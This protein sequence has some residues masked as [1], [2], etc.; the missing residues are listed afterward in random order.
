MLLEK[1][2][3]IKNFAKNQYENI[4]KRSGSINDIDFSYDIN[5]QPLTYIRMWYV[6]WTVFRLKL[7]FAREFSFWLLS[8]RQWR[9]RGGG[10]WTRKWSNFSYW[11]STSRKK[12]WKIAHNEAIIES[13]L[14]EFD[15][16]VADEN[17]SVE[18][19]CYFG[20]EMS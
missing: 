9:V 20:G 2:E 17:D 7:K 6:D 3:W 5:T 12:Q 8:S 13:V 1:Y 15:E 16:S 18:L 4:I 19:Q 14:L 11:P 10:E